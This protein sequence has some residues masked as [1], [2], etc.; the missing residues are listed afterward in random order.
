MNEHTIIT[1]T[2]RAGE[3]PEQI[4]LRTAP[5][6]NPHAVPIEDQIREQLIARL[7]RQS[8]DPLVDRPLHY[9]A[10]D[11]TESLDFIESFKLGF[12]EA[13]IIQYLVRWRKKNGLQDLYKGRNL[14]DRLILIAEA[15]Q[16]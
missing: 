14:L 10:D 3:T 15:E 13:S 9:V 6:G 7:N 2:P 16:G 12:H 1:N 5:R 11:G 4:A 8:G